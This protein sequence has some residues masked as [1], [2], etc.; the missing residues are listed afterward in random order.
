MKTVL[1]TGSQ[2]FIAK[3]LTIALSKITDIKVVGFAKTDDLRSLNK[4][5]LEADF[6]YHLA[7][8]NRPQ[9]E[10]E[11]RTGNTELTKTITNI[12]QRGGK[13]TPIVISSSTQAAQDNPYGKSKREAEQAVFAYGQKCEAPVYVYRLTR[14]FG[15]WSRP[16]YNSVVATFCH[17]IANDLPIAISNPGKAVEFVYIDDVVA[18]FLQVLAGAVSG[19]QNYLSVSPIH[20]ITLGA[21]ADKIYQ[22]KN[23]QKTSEIPDLSDVFTKKLYATYLFYS[24]PRAGGV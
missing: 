19:S 20:T 11:F 5:V 23:M 21:L 9:H 8:V 4:M 14:V 12:L 6:I 17:N 2:G 10:D 7:G 22:F 24:L 3:N 15:K 13:A 16:N 1:V 18:A